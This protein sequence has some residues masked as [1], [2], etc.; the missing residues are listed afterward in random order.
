MIIFPPPLAGDYAAMRY[1]RVPIELYELPMHERQLTRLEVGDVLV[2]VRNSDPRDGAQ[3]DEALMNLRGGNVSPQGQAVPEVIEHLISRGALIPLTDDLEFFHS[4]SGDSTVSN[5]PPTAPSDFA[6]MKYYRVTANLSGSV[7][8]LN[9]NPGDVL[10]RFGVAGVTDHLIQLRNGQE[11]ATPDR[12]TG[13]LIDH[14][15]SQGAIEELT[16]C[17]PIASLN[18]QIVALLP[19][20]TGN[21]GIV[22]Q[23]Q[24]LTTQ[25]AARV[26]S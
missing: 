3:L 25:I 21:A 17:T 12:P 10:A 7:R 11:V 2:H 4:L 5:F 20:I 18:A 15:I 9:L 23:L 6:A 13:T 26:E 19:S 14:L 24:S 1:Y 22:S 8:G 16:D